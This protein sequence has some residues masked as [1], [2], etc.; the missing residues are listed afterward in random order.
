MYVG[1][2]GDVKGFDNNL[3]RYIRYADKN[4]AQLIN[5][6]IVRIKE[7]QDFVDNTLIKFVEVLHDLSLIE[8]RFYN[9]IKYGSDDERVICL[10]RNGVSLGSAELLIKKYGDLIQ[11]DVEMSTV[12]Y[13]DDLVK[14]MIKSKENL[15]QIHEIK[16]CM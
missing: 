10:I 13:S 16:S 15:I 8:E 2:W 4:E 3:P 7:E 14:E 12:V 1:K 5:L 9:Q 11:I 6:A